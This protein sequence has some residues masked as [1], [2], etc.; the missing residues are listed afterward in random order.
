MD[1]K[2]DVL[3][4]GGGFAG[5][6]ITKRLSKKLYNITLL[7]MNNFHSFP[8]L[9][10]QVASS[11]LEVESICFPFRSQ[12]KKLPH[13]RFVMGRLL[14]V[15]TIKNIAKSTAGNI[16][17]DILIIATGTVTNFFGNN[18][19]K[20]HAFRLKSTTEA[21]K[22]RNQTLYSLEQAA[23]ATNPTLREKY[24]TFVVV[25]AGATGVEVAGALGE[26]KKFVIKREYP[27]LNPHD[28]KVVLV[29]GSSKV[30]SSMDEKD[31]NM[32]KKYLE[33][34]SVDVQLNRTILNYNGETVTF[35]DGEEIQ[36]STVIWCAG[37]TGEPLDGLPADSFVKGRYATNKFNQIE[38]LNNIYAIGDIAMC[39][40]D[41]YPYGHPQVAQVA[42]QQGIN[43]AK[44]L[45]K[46]GK[47]REFK[48]FDKGN[49]ATI[50]RNKAVVDI[51]G[52]HLKG[53]FA[54]VTWMIVHL[55][56][57]LGM[58]N[59]IVIFINWVWSYLS[60]STSLRLII[61]SP[62]GDNKL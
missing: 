61:R 21:I 37:V 23:S 60:Y 33:E 1:S 50:G 36:S 24:Q 44:N 41:R 31:S 46:G 19:I 62:L 40:S 25:G 58:K 39:A 27:E 30:L 9:F 11:G 57:L 17:F 34:L 7:D 43:L 22:V 4:V 6:N 14:R 26:M 35:S 56:S 15:D 55:M 2:R 5:L 3:I 29:E 42:I 12:L 20:E 53:F 51:N 13:V 18:T 28:I 8:P 47:W 59:K 54:W 38:N 32:A 10:Y 45:N 48:Y 49:M 52:V 16:P